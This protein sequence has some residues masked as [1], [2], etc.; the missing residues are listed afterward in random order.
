[1]L[2]ILNTTPDNA[3]IAPSPATTAVG[4]FEFQ[5]VPLSIAATCLKDL[6]GSKEGGGLRSHVRVLVTGTVVVGD[7]HPHSGTPLTHPH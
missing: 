6:R 3:D 7:P 4:T 1:M 2:T 5:N